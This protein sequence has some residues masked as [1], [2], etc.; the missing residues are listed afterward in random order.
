[1][2]FNPWHHGYLRHLS[3]LSET[4]KETQTVETQ[5]PSSWL[6]DPRNRYGRDSRIYYNRGSFVGADLE[7]L[8]PSYSQRNTRM[9]GEQLYLNADEIHDI[10]ASLMGRNIQRGERGQ[11]QTPIRHAERRVSLYP[12]DE[13]SSRAPAGLL[14]RARARMVNRQNTASIYP[15]D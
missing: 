1:M 9:T 6:S 4:E 10:N 8:A 14:P 11:K 7:Y 12:I 3:V 2:R 13:P 15:I 5:T